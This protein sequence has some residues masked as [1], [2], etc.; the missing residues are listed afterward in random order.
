MGGFTF[1]LTLLMT[2][3]GCWS[4]DVSHLATAVDIPLLV[5]PGSLLISALWGVNELFRRQVYGLPKF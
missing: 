1:L 2:L 5:A 3:V 4:G